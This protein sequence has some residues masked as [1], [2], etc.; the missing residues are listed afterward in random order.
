MATI[1]T[2]HDLAF[3]LA[4]LAIV[5]APHAICTYLAIREGQNNGLAE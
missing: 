2:L 3:V 1:K 4:S 5:M